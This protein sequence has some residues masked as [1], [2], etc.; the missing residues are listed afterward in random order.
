VAAQERALALD[1]DLFQSAGSLVIMRAEAGELETALREARALLGR[2]PDQA[3]SHHVLAYVLRYGGQFDEAQRHCEEALRRDPTNYGWRS[4]ALAYYFAGE[5]DRA[6]VFIR[7][8]AGSAW[9]QRVTGD[10]LLRRGDIPAMMEAMRQLPPDSEPRVLAEACHGERGDPR[11]VAREAAEALASVPDSEPKYSVGAILARCGQR[12]PALRLL[13]LAVAEGY[14]AHP[15]V[16]LD[17]LWAGL[18][19]DPE[20]QAIRREAIRCRERFE[21]AMEEE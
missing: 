9:A 8:D 10:L 11:A 19:G 4:C 21:A 14:C 15:A 2:R 17:P 20:F 5:L 12:E 3:H 1:P 16:D 6:E 7:L 18:R 13:R